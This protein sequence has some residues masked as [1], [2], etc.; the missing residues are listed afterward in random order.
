MKK[1]KKIFSTIIMVVGLFGILLGS[2]IV[3]DNY[4]KIML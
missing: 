2:M 4:K 1:I 3:S